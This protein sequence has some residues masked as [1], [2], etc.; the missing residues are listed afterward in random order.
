MKENYRRDLSQI[1]FFDTLP[2]DEGERYPTC[3]EDCTEIKRMEILSK[4]EPK[5]VRECG[6]HLD[7]IFR[8]LWAML[9]EDER[10]RILALTGGR[11]PHCDTN[12]ADKDLP[13]EVNRFC[14]ILRGIADM[15]GICAKGSEAAMQKSRR[16]MEDEE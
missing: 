8:N 13:K 6:K 11:V 4:K 3:I 7:T 9:R 1:Y 10:D 5:Y 14:K 15:S 12:V 16:D 2:Q